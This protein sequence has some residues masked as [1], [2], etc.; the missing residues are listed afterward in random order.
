MQVDPIKPT[1]K[2]PG[3]QL[4]KPKFYELLSSFAFK[5]KL[6][7]Y[8]L[9]ELLRHV[10]SLQPAGI[11][12]AL[13]ILRRLVELGGG[14]PGPPGVTRDAEA[15]ER[16]GVP[17]AGDAAVA[18][19]VAAARE[20]VAAAAAGETAAVAAVGAAGDSPMEEDGAAVTSAP[21]VS[22]PPV[23]MTLAAASMTTAAV[24]GARAAALGAAVAAAEAAVV[25]AAAAGPAGAAA[26]GEAAVAAVAAAEAA[27]LRGTAGAARTTAG[28]G[29]GTA[30]VAV[31]PSFLTEAVA[32]TA[33]LI[34][35]M[36]PTEECARTFVDLGGIDY[37]L[38]LHTLPLLPPTFSSSSSCHALSVTLRAL[39][40]A[41]PV[42]RCRLS[43]SNPS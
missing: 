28:A 29:T 24:T 36:L 1:L 33:R 2:A 8:N 31:S 37:L 22:A 42:G 35:S 38:Q 40:G 27:G 39:A 16:T 7:R 5:F 11:N 12:L 34:D 20:T 18:A 30:A 15:A 4:L 43:L 41:H 3:P 14:D 26:A 25:A 10:P 21:P 32:N 13:D 23:S 17:M 19:A 6:R 9:D